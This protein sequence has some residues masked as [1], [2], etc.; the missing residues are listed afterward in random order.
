MILIPLSRARVHI[1][2]KSSYNSRTPETSAGV[3]W[4]IEGGVFKMTSRSSFLA[5]PGNGTAAYFTGVRWSFR[6]ST[7]SEER[8]SKAPAS[9]SNAVILMATHVRLPLTDGDLDMNS[10]SRSAATSIECSIS[11]TIRLWGGV[12]L[13]FFE[14]PPVAWFSSTS[15]E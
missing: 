14:E 12:V 5:D 15:T 13:T 9:G 11:S 4:P 3:K 1:L 6:D 2:T 8:A 10:S 7:I